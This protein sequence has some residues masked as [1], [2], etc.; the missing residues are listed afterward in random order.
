MTQREKYEKYVSELEENIAFKKQMLKD[1]YCYIDWLEK[2]ADAL[3]QVMRPIKD[4][5]GLRLC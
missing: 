4:V 2:K 3:D 5:P 1:D